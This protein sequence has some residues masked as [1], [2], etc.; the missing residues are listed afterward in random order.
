M[1]IKNRL[2]IFSLIFIIKDTYANL[3]LQCITSHLKSHGI[4]ED[5][6]DSVDSFPGTEAECESFIRIKLDDFNDKIFTSMNEDENA[7]AH[8]ECFR[9]EAA[10]EEYENVAL[11]F[12]AVGMLDVGWKFWRSSAKELRYEELKEE[13]DQL[14][15]RILEKCA[16]AE[17]FG[18]FFD[19]AIEKKPSLYAKGENEYCIR[20]YLIDKYMIDAFSYSLNINPKNVTMENYNCEEIM[21]SI[22]DP[23]YDNLK[24]EENECSLN[25]LKDNSYYDYLLKL[26]L[27]SKLP[28]TSQDKYFERQKF[29]DSMFE[30]TQKTRI[31]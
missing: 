5:I 26:E 23:A 29:I 12:Q 16:A 2:I 24:K 31:C 3:S 4:Q 20:R 30:I 13:I 7:R 6:L 18:K 28:L 21:K 27:L 17:H 1:R 22:L 14:G 19:T 25:I 9:R 15:V 11:R 10:S 8:I